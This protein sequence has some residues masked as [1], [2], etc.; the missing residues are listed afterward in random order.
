MR[1]V[2]DVD[3]PDE[4]TEVFIDR[5]I[6][7]QVD[8]GIPIYVVVDIDRERLITRMETYF[9]PRPHQRRNRAP[10]AG[11]DGLHL[12]IQRPRRARTW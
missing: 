3:D 12:T 7:M 11:L 5:M 4:V 10:G 6:D 2:V 8:D 1:A 9:D